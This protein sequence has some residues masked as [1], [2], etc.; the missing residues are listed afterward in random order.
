MQSGD[1]ANAWQSDAAC[2]ITIQ[3]PRTLDLMKERAFPHAAPGSNSKEEQN[4][5]DGTSLSP[6]IL[7]PSHPQPG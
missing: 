6:G 1:D 4:H 3:G 2:V 5:T 7:E